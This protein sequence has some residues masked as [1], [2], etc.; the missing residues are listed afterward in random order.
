MGWLIALLPIG[1][2]LAI[3]AW[4]FNADYDGACGLLDAGW[5]CSRLEYVWYSFTN[6][7]TL[8]FLM[9]YVI[10][11]LFAVGSVAFCVRLYCRNLAK[12]QRSK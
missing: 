3:L 12:R 11:W 1:G 8:F 10:A 6:P 5:R 4:A 2:C 9:A 7:L